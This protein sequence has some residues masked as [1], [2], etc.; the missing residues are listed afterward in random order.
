MKKYGKDINS[1]E[2]WDQMA[3]EY[4]DQL[5]NL[6]HKHRMAVIDSLIPQDLYKTNAKIMDFGCGDA[7]HFEQF[8]QNGCSINGVDVS[9][10]M[11]ELAKKRLKTLNRN[12]ELAKIG[13]VEALQEIKSCS[14]DAILSFNVL[15]Y[16]NDDEIDVFYKEAYRLIRPGGYL[17]VTHSNELFD[18]FSLNQYTVNFIKKYLTIEDKLKSLVDPLINLPLEELEISSYNVRENPL[19]YKFKLDRYGFTE[20][21]QEFINL[22]NAPPRLLEG[23]KSY[24]NTLAWNKEDKWKLMFTCSTYGSLSIRK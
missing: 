14:L 22:H 20:V 5:V 7:I 23:G 6:Y 2:A 10:D 17:I 8:L 13:G 11:I 18:L 24:P 3:K 1:T 4:S 19:S 9:R 12:P 21:Q 16:L 15:A